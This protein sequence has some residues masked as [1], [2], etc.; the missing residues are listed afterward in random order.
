MLEQ[1]KKSSIK[2]SLPAP[3]ILLMIGIALFAS[4]VSNMLALFRGRVAFESLEPD[5]IANK[6]IVDA[7]IDANF[8]CYLKEYEENTKTHYKHTTNLYY[9]IWTGDEDA[10]DYRYMGI[11]VP[12]SDI[13]T[14]DK[15]AEAAYNGMRSDPVL[16]SGAILKMPSEEYQYFKEYFLESGWTEEEFEE[17]TLPYYIN[18]G[19]LVGGAAVSAYI[20]AGIGFGLALLGICLLIHALKGGHLKAIRKELA[21]AGFGENDADYEYQGARL[22]NK[23]ND[24]RIGKRLTFFMLANIPHAL[25]NDK[26]VW[27]YQ[28]RTTHRTN[29]IKTGTTYAVVLHMYDKKKFEIFVRGEDGAMEVLEYINQEMPWA[30]LGYDD[31]LNSM[32]Y[33]D[34][35]SFLNLRYNQT[36]K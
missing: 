15:M 16:Y 33:H 3:I 10:V 26:I 13:K 22:F 11:K 36:E 28:K 6:V 31:D 1:L 35:Q 4:E 29:G 23:E 32:F 2:K 19:S 27:A 5:E 9:V 25:S 8:G 12:A 24:F 20:F 17:N 21:A 18:V 14:M 34:Y 30:A 7:S